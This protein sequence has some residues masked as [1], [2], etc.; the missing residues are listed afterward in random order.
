MTGTTRQAQQTRQAR[1][2]MHD[3]TGT[4]RQARHETRGKGAAPADPLVHAPARA[5]HGMYAG[6]IHPAACTNGISGASPRRC[7]VC[8]RFHGSTVGGSTVE[9]ALVAATGAAMVEMRKR[10]RGSGGSGGGESDTANA[11]VAR[12]RGGEA[13]R[14]R[15]GEAGSSC[16]C[17][18]CHPPLVCFER[19]T[20]TAS[21]RQ[22]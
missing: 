22:R 8:G 6:Y 2:E 7:A 18:L 4:S 21:Q 3:M 10:I 17:E 19:A 12:R 15:G 5:A 20:A 9:R 11:R 16:M 1:H 14:R 13:A